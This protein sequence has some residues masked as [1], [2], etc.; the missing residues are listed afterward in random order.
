MIFG[1]KSAIYLAICLLIIKEPVAAKA[2]LLYGAA[3]FIQ[4]FRC[5]LGLCQTQ[6]NRPQD[7]D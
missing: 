6:A 3:D 1:T 5:A 7:P 2:C 4:V